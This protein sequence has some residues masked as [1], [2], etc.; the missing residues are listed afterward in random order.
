MEAV[1]L[2]CYPYIP[3]QAKKNLAAL[4]QTC[5]SAFCLYVCPHALPYMCQFAFNQ[6]WSKF[7]GTQTNSDASRSA[8]THLQVDPA[9]AH[10]VD[11]PLAISQLAT[12]VWEVCKFEELRA[13]GGLL[14]VPV[15]VPP[16][17]K[18]LCGT[19]SRLEAGKWAIFRGQLR[20]AHKRVIRHE[21]GCDL[22]IAAR[23]EINST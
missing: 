8:Q 21:V 15:T 9:M 4:E 5:V 18:A 19:V 23:N 3:D 1:H 10:P 7:D 11:Q 14:Y 17:F 20:R 6:L 22:S 16:T 12:V 13:I 2:D